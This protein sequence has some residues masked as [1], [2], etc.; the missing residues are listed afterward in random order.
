MRQCST[1]TSIG[2]SMT[3]SNGRLSRQI[4][5]SSASALTF[6]GAGAAQ[7]A[8]VETQQATPVT[9][10][11]Q[12]Q[13]AQVRPVNSDEIVITGTR[14]TD[15]TSTNSASPVDVIGAQEL[16]SQPTA[17]ILDTIK[18]I[19]PSFYVGQNTISD[20]STFVRAPSLRGLPGDEV[21]VQ[22][23]GKRFNRSALVQVFTNGDTGLS[24]GSQG[25]DISAIPAIGIK[26]LQVLRDGATAQYG[27][28]AI[29]G[30]MNFGMRTDRSGIELEGRYGQY[31]DHGST[32]L[33]SGKTRQ[34]AGN[35]GV[36]IGATGF[37]DVA[38]EYFSDDG[39]SRGATRPVA[40]I[41]ATQFP[42]LA[43]QLPNYP[44]PAQIWGSSPQHGWKA[45]LNS[46]VDVTSNSQLYLTLLGAYS[47]ANESFNFRSTVRATGVLDVAGNPHTLGANEAF[48]APFFLTPCP[49]ATPT[50]PAGGFVN[51]TNTFTFLSIYPAGFTPRF[52]GI[53]KERFGTLGYKGSLAN[54]L[55]WDLS[56]SLAKNTLTLS[57]NQSL[58]TTYGPNSQTSFQFGTLSQK[59][60]NLNADFTYPVNLGLFS[61]VTL[62]WGAEYRKE[63]YGSTAGDVQSYSGGPFVA[64]QPLYNLVSPGVYAPT[65]FSATP[66]AS[67]GLGCSN[68][69]ATQ[70]IIAGR[71]PGASGYGGTSPTYA[72]EWSQWSWGVYGDAEADVTS[73][74]SVG[75]AG[76]YEHY[77]T[78]GGSFV[79]KANAIYKI[80]PQVSIRGT[81]GTGF[82][83]PSPGQ[84]H[85]ALLT[86]NF[87]GGNQ[88]QT[89]TYPVDSPISRHFGSTTLGP[90]KS[91][92]YGAGLVLKPT[93]ALT[94][95]ID[96]YIINVR[97]RIGISQ[98]FTVTAAD[99]AAEPTL[100]AVG[101][102]GAVN[103]FT[104]GF[105]TTTK[106]VDFVGTYRT[107][108]FDGSMTWTL[109]YNY[110]HSKVTKFDPG[111]I[112]LGQRI[113][114]EHLAPNHRAT[115]SMNWNRGP[116]SLNA[117]ENY[118][119]WWTSATDFCTGQLTTNCQ[120]PTGYQHF[121]S[122]FTTDADVSYTFM[123][124]F[125]LTIGAN[126]IFNNHPDKVANSAVN[127]VYQLTHSLDNGMVYPRSGGPF[128]IN[129]GLW[130]V[131]L[132]AKYG[133]RAPYV[134]PAPVAVPPPPPPVVEAP[135]P[136]APPPPPPP[137]PPA[138]KGERGQ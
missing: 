22:I 67:G 110:N 58:N 95:T 108:L 131:R 48:T 17:N 14:R 122:K 106:G 4:L 42:N 98:T 8:Q 46:G 13:L 44:L 113:N 61:P 100:A 109:A 49:A 78:F 125:T 16:T 1:R 117:R 115:L 31:F 112:S 55:T 136:P 12:D 65:P 97:D 118:Y 29:A 105:D 81:I 72:G 75:L 138:E 103:Y 104:N 23:N 77:N 3:K 5:L 24:F 116:F 45:A 43:A 33:D 11:T 52:I 6:F 102:N 114:I 88:V 28:D 63:T 10:V 32:K 73:Q 101:L 128:G 79:Y 2:G 127:A 18:N 86:T 83:A 71:S 53:N 82:H 137:P 120:V 123:R 56:G 30:V 130:Y 7:A 92:N 40:A 129:G 91:H 68:L 19:V 74:L 84:S 50:C 37:I 47:K 27:S 87:V 60:R 90:E 124:M 121:G 36:G 134:A 59:E 25:S 133:E 80:I 34:V 64:P 41:F 15:R 132:K 26:N 85:D 135:P 96:G 20:A 99:L 69:S 21:L 35:I 94:A 9:T 66:F 111:V 126:N 51:N 107:H 39:T 76:R 89:G 62:A 57:M 70:C 54:G 38:G 93:P 119:S